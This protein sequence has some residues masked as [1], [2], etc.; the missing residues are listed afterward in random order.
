MNDVVNRYR[1]QWDNHKEDNFGSIMPLLI[2]RVVWKDEN[3]KYCEL[4]TESEEAAL[5]KKTSVE[6]SNGKYTYVN[7]EGWYAYRSDEHVKRFLTPKRELT[8][9]DI[10]KRS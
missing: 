1:N 4:W 5:E 8:W 3:G 9:W 6:H 10:K 7:F 2:Y